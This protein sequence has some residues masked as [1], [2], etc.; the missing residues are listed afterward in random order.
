MN[1]SVGE[2]GRIVVARFEDGDQIIK[3]LTEIV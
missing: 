1:Y 2:A 3:G